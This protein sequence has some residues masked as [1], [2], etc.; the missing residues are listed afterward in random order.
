VSKKYHPSIP[1][2]KAFIGISER[3][4]NV[5][6]SR[7]SPATYL[8]WVFSKRALVSSKTILGNK[9]THPTEK[10]TSAFLQEKN[11]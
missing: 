8:I 7:T 9:V 10:Q 6:E 11:M 1:Q 4:K 5:G 2:T 3:F